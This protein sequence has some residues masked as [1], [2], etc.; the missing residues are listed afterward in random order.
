MWSGN[1]G[2]LFV[3]NVSLVS[4]NININ[5][6]TF[7]CLYVHARLTEQQQFKFEA[8]NSSYRRKKKDVSRYILYPTLPQEWT[9]TVKRYRNNK[10]G[11]GFFCT[12]LKYSRS[13]QSR[14]SNCIHAICLDINEKKQNL[15]TLQP[16]DLPS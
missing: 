1:S 5:C 4:I 2:F 3:F 16:I 9:N 6:E 7:V 12:F 10:S 13:I 14:F 15:T 11:R 8:F